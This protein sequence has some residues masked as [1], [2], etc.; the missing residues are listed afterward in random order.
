MKLILAPIFVTISFAVSA[1]A[2]NCLKPNVDSSFIYI[3]RV[4]EW[5]DAPANWAIY[6]DTEKICKLSN[7]KF[8]QVPTKPGKHIISARVGGVVVLK[9][10]TRLKVEVEVG[11]SN[12]IACKVENKLFKRARLEMMEVTKSS[13]DEQMGKMTLDHCEEGLEEQNK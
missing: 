3:F 6:L 2:S 1:K 11:G 4:G 9:K 7:N 10:E 8:V 13:A 5:V 12:Y